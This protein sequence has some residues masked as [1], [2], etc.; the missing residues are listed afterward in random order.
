M[1]KG[2]VLALVGLAAPVLPA[3][4]SEGAEGSG[5]GGLLTVDGGLMI[6]TIII[7]VALFILLKKFAWPQ[8]LGAVEAREQRL[9]AALLESER[10]RAEAA[11]L[12]EEQKR[13]LAEAKT[14]AQG[15]VAE[16]K[17]LADKERMAALERARED[18]EELLARAQREIKSEREKAIAD[19]R[20]EV[21]DLALTAASK[22]IEEKVDSEADRKLIT[23][24]L[25]TVG[26]GR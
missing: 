5:G 6:W 17:Q 25:T 12:L 16:A 8:I 19:I 10:N 21:V 9:E 26:T 1:R 20:R 13:M 22:L 7:F 23:N 18:Q 3:L 2:I 24:Y 11:A 14:T 15:I 4:A